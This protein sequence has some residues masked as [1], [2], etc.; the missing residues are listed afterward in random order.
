[1]TAFILKGP[2]F[3]HTT[4]SGF[5]SDIPIKH[6]VRLNSFSQHEIAEKVVKIVVVGFVIERE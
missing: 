6:H 3:I 4:P 1:M 5:A 2:T